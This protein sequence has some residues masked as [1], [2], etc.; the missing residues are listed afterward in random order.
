MSKNNSSLKNFNIENLFSGSVSKPH[1]NGK[2]DINTLF[3]NNIQDADFVADPD[4]LLNGARQRKLKLEDVHE[5]IFRGCWRAII[6]ANSSGLIDIFYDVPENIIECIDYDSK[7]CM[8]YIKSKLSEQCI[9]SLII[10]KSKT[11]MFIT[12]EDLEKRLIEKEK[13]QNYSDIN[14]LSAFESKS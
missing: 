3:K 12:W 6:E 13:K 4:V 1:T 2:L 7:N 11:Q 14:T 5:D 9:Q 8:K 10:S